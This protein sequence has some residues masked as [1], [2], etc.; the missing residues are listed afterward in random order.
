MSGMDMGRNGIVGVTAEQRSDPG[1]K[2]VTSYSYFE[3]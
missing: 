3:D 1:D 2:K